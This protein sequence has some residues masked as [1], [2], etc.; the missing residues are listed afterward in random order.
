MEK[1]SRNGTNVPSDKF[2]EDLVLDAHGTVLNDNGITTLYVPVQGHDP[3][4]VQVSFRIGTPYSELTVKFIESDQS[5][6]VSTYFD[7]VYQ[8]DTSIN[9][10]SIVAKI[11]FGV[12]TLS[13]ENNIKI[14]DNVHHIVAVQ[15]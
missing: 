13:F 3:R 6:P 1:L 11:K 14:D 15:Y 12:L 2:I 8:V 7:K 5:S 4:N 9:C 10:N